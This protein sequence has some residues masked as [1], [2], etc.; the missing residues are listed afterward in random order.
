[1]AGEPRQAGGLGFQLAN[2]PNLDAALA[3]RRNLRRDLNG[4]VQV[5]DIDQI[6]AG[7]L[8][9]RSANGPSVM[10]TFPLRTRTVVAV[11]IG[12]SASAATS[13]PL[14]R[15]PLPQSWHSLSGT[16]RSFSSSR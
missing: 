14:A 13:T 8:L 10:V 2:R 16:A 5:G 3:R 11:S 7:E 6:E 15:K 1:L 4:L 9:L 12:L